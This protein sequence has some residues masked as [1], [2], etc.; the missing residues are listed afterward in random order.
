VGYFKL[1]EFEKDICE[2]IS[3]LTGYSAM[4]VRDI[5][6]GTFLRQLELFMRGKEVIVPFLG[7][8]LIKFDGDDI[9]AGTRVAKVEC[10]FSPSELLKRM[11]GDIKDGE[12]DILRNLL[13]KKISK[14]LRSILD[15]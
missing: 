6:E 7:K 2:E 1:E 11:V 10:L 3:T 4:A 12:S 5:L 8:M 14:E 15:E 13:S 9:V